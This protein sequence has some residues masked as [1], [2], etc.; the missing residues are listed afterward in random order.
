M[1]HAMLYESIGLRLPFYYGVIER[2]KLFPQVHEPA[3]FYI[4]L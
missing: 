2:Y 4:G 1:H 3:H